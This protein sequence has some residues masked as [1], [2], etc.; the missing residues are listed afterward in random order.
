M[1][2]TVSEFLGMALDGTY[3]FAIYDFSKGKNIF[4][5]WHEDSETP[6]EIEDMIVESWELENGK[7][8]FNVDNGNE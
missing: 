2:I 6:E 3:E 7:I 8:V 4:E 5:S 1:N